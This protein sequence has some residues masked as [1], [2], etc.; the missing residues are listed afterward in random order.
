[1]R[2]LDVAGVA[3]GA[4]VLAS[5]ASNTEWVNTKNRNAE[6]ASDYNQCE[7]SSQQDPKVQAGARALLMRQIDRCM[8]KEGWILVEKP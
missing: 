3:A 7:M 2:L 8:A 5:C 1:M 6:Y 4:F